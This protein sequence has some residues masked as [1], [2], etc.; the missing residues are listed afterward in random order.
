MQKV[1]RL[2]LIL[3]LF[4]MNN[5][6]SGALGN[7]VDLT[8]RPSPESVDHQFD[9]LGESNGM[10]PAMDKSKYETD[11]LLREA[12]QLEKIDAGQG[13]AKT[14]TIRGVVKTISG[15]PVPGVKVICWPIDSSL[16]PYSA[17]RLL[18]S[19]KMR[20]L[21][22][23]MK[24]GSF[25]IE[26]AP[27]NLHLRLSAGGNGWA[28][29]RSATCLR[30]ENEVDL[31]VVRVYGGKLSFVDEEKRAPLQGILAW[32]RKPAHFFSSQPA[33]D[34]PSDHIGLI[35]AGIPAAALMNLHQ[36]FRPD[37]L[38][39]ATEQ[40]SAESLCGDFI[41]YLSSV[42]TTAVKVCL[43][44]VGTEIAVVEVPVL[45]MEIH[46]RPIRLLWNG[47]KLESSNESIKSMPQIQIQL[48][49]MND[50]ETIVLPWLRFGQ[51]F[52]YAGIPLGK[53][54]VKTRV[55]GPLSGHVSVDPKEIEITNS[56]PH[57]A[58]TLKVF[59]VTSASLGILGEDKKP[60]KGEVS[61]LVCDGETERIF[62]DQYFY[63][64]PYEFP[65]VPVGSVFFR[66]ILG[67]LGSRVRLS[68]EGKAGKTIVGNLENRAD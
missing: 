41:F 34:F 32:R 61:V 49:G 7:T 10:N 9:G 64:P 2:T 24:D 55:F 14:R 48:V 22:I 59:G 62:F 21:A 68:V 47:V 54:E 58:I 6:L 13:L 60:Y 5:G 35:M 23:S 29:Q 30:F 53:Y 20:W 56:G 25:E 1:F 26:H 66:A 16:N 11:S 28:S 31:M 19:G 52:E 17:E 3:A 67:P 12:G 63:G 37:Y 40:M 43:P 50:E 18:A 51:D 36:G 39:V 65:V 27:T 57:P 15:E 38:F 45:S 8:Y 42:T 33:V 46:T 44:P 4:W